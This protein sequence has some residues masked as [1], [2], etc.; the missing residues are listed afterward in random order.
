MCPDNTPQ[1]FKSCDPKKCPDKEPVNGSSCSFY[2][3]SDDCDYDHKVMGCSADTQQCSP[4]KYY[5]C[6]EDPIG[7]TEIWRMSYA[8]SMAC[9]TGGDGASCDPNGCPIQAPLIGSDCSAYQGVEKCM[10]NYLFTAGCTIESMQCNPTDYFSC[11]AQDNTWARASMAVATPICQ[12]RSAVEL[13][14][15]KPCEKCPS[16]EPADRCPSEK[17][18]PGTRCV[19]VGYENGLTCNY[20]FEYFGCTEDELKCTP[21]NTFQCTRLRGWTVKTQLRAENSCGH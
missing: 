3:G 10:Y 6:D 15:G 21:I 4:S 11:D 16:V 1:G 20:D 2:Q 5:T 17:P 8:L 19:D 9:W 13:P 12:S 18:S 14:M 7:R